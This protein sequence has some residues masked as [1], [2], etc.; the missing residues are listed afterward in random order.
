MIIYFW[1]I[2]V[3][4]KVHVIMDNVS[5]KMEIPVIFVRNQTQLIHVDLVQNY[6]IFLNQL[7]NVICLKINLETIVNI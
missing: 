6:L 5:V 7:V 3:V 1:D 4:N 2:N